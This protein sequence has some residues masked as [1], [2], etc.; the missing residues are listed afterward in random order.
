MHLSPSRYTVLEFL[1]AIILSSFMDKHS[2]L[3]VYKM[4]NVIL[5]IMFV[6]I[7]TQFIKNLKCKYFTYML[8]IISF[9]FIYFL[10]E[11]HSSVIKSLSNSDS[12]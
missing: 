7:L 9:Y 2:F 3:F 6:K 10:L 11:L 1:T 4:F 5:N 12:L 8:Y